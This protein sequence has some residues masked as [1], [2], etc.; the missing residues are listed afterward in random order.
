MIIK[1][2]VFTSPRGF[3]RKAQLVHLL[4]SGDGSPSSASLS[5]GRRVSSRQRSQACQA[6]CPVK[7]VISP[8]PAPW[9]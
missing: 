2:T 5:L 1:H 4:D 7:A 8:Q 3:L 6:V 9:L